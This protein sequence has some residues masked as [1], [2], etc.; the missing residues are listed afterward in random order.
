VGN[1]NVLRYS[2]ILCQISLSSRFFRQSIHSNLPSWATFIAYPV[3]GYHIV[4]R[5]REISSAEAVSDKAL[6]L[7]ALVKNGQPIYDHD[8]ECFTGVDWDDTPWGKMEPEM[9]CDVARSW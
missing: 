6:G 2:A 3:A 9:R 5:E 1:A 4:K 8:L 7:C